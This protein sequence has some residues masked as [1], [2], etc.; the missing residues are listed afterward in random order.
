MPTES[1]RIENL[2]TG[3]G[4]RKVLK[5][6]SMVVEEGSVVGIIGPNGHGKSTLVKALSGL[7]STW[8]G[9]IFLK[10]NR[11]RDIDYDKELDQIILVSENIP[12]LLSLRRIEK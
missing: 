9:R 11:I 7:I 5:N 10:G 12:S 6:L 1:L 3:Y 4:R 2:T 8:E